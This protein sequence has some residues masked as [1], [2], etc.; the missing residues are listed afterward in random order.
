[1]YFWTEATIPFDSW[2]WSREAPVTMTIRSAL[3]AV[4]VVYDFGSR[5]RAR[6]VF[7]ETLNGFPKTDVAGEV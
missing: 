2:K 7:I 3:A 5:C 6:T 1:M 4:S